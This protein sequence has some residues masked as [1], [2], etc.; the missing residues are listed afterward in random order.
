MTWDAVSR[1]EACGSR[2]EDCECVLPPWHPDVRECRN[3]LINAPQVVLE[4][5]AEAKQ[6]LRVD[7]AGG[8]DNGSVSDPTHGGRGGVPRADIAPLASGPHEELI[9][10][11]NGMFAR[12]LR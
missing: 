6:V 10:A 11:L 8:G 1:C 12:V 3:Q 9:V 2:C 4:P 5:P 7:G